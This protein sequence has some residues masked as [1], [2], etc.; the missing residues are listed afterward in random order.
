MHTLV[1]AASHAPAFIHVADESE[2]LSATPSWHAEAG[3]VLS[4]VRLNVLD[5]GMREVPLTEEVVRLVKVG[6][7][8]GRILG[9]ALKCL[10][11]GLL[12]PLSVPK[13]VQHA[14]SVF[15]ITLNS[16]CAIP[17]RGPRVYSLSPSDEY[18]HKRSLHELFFLVFDYPTSM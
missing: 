15:S 4:G 10:L 17:R 1:V 13:R 8:A 6:W 11:Q 9:E 2:V 16:T 18:N 3:S 12:P 7:E 5:E 14:P